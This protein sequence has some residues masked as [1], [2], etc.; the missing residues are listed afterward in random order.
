M[1]IIKPIAKFNYEELNNFMENKISNLDH[2]IIVS[3]KFKKNNLSFVL[4]DDKQIKAIC[5]LSYEKNGIS[6]K[7]YKQ[8]TFFGISLPGVIISD[9]LSSKEIRQ[10][11]SSILLEIDRLCKK[12][13]IKNIKICFSDLINFDLN[14]LK[15]QTLSRLLL[16]FNY[17]NISMVGNRID[18]RKDINILNKSI[19][20]GHKAIL[21]SNNYLL[22]YQGSEEK[23]NYKS[24]FNLIRQVR[25]NQEYI[26]YLYEF[27]K[28]NQLEIVNVYEGKEKIAFAIFTK[29][30][31][32]VE[33]FSS[34]NIYKDKNVHH[35]LI[36]DA[37]NKYKKDGF[38]F[39]NLG[40]ISYGSQLHYVPSKKHLN[41]S[42]FK[43]GFKGENYPLQIY[44]KYFS[45]KVFQ[46]Q[47]N[48][49]IKNFSN[50]IN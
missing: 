41:I 20:K 24:F 14:S 18:L 47:Q 42:I 39:L 27:Y 13:S 2:K 16:Q 32:T 7:K 5:P 43:R 4:M 36:L 6:N 30:N 34:K 19:S 12:H 38:S 10:I 8:G 9:N 40:V 50:L 11:L 45:K 22:K 33:Y 1:I 25:D 49:R 26:K 15:F 44:E 46:E 48:I 29:V 28:N 37:I 23:L 31:K 17:L 3:K 35:S 21:K